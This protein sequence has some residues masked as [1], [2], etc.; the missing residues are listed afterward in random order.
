LQKQITKG[1]GQV[2]Q[3]FLSEIQETLSDLMM[4]N[5][6]NYFCQKLLSA[7][8]SEQ[9]LIVLQIIQEQFINICCNKKG[10]HSIQQIIDLIT[11]PQE[12]ELIMS[13]LRGNIVELARDAQGAHVVQKVLDTF[14]SETKRQFIFDE[15]YLCFLD[16]AKNSN[17]LCVIKKLILLYAPTPLP[18]ANNS[19]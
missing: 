10:T 14:R 18:H 12:E 2:V 19:K 7:C 8:T 16:L 6:G 15:V 13:F 5:Y 4:D 11:Q 1:Q 3:F 9:R 17:G